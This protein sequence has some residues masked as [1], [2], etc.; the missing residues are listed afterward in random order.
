[1]NATE[2]LRICMSVE[3]DAHDRLFSAET[4]ARLH[5]A[6]DVVFRETTGRLTETELAVLGRG[7]RAVITGW[8]T[9]RL[10]A[11][12]L[13]A[14]PNL[15]LIAHTGIS[16][17]P[18]VDASL[19]R[20][21]VRV[22]N[23]GDAMTVPVAEFTLMQILRALRSGMRENAALKDAGWGICDNPAGSDL[24][25]ATVGV[26]GAGRIGRRVIRLL[27]A[28][29]AI[30]RV[31]DPLLSEADAAA[32][33]AA[34]SS[35]DDLLRASRIVTLHAPAIAA[36]RGMVG[37]RELAL[38]PDGA[39]LV[40]TSRPSLVDGEAL[41]RE[42]RSG[43]LSAALDVFDR[44]PLPA[45]DPLRSL[46]NVLLSPHAAFMTVECLHRLGDA[47]VDEVLRFARDEPL[48]NEVT[49]DKIETMT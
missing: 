10:T 16:V 48:R 17:R 13:E 28:F 45:D 19:F 31:H 40:N 4:L 3:P 49:L 37:T 34:R 42:L 25:G 29:D 15:R 47:A 30:V 35:L 21:G 39:W 8:N 46:P 36:T 5:S 1:M 43:R 7:C 12:L 18:Y 32:M 41:M 44:E 22:T 11:D 9:A 2:K 23:A 33:D 38:M 24:A 20:A 27:R 14:L 26:I 6:C